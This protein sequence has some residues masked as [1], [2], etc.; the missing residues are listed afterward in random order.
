[1]LTVL[2]KH[3]PDWAEGMAAALQKTVH[4]GRHKMS[5][6]PRW[7]RSGARLRG[8]EAVDP[9][10]RRRTDKGTNV[11]E[12]A[13]LGSAAWAVVPT[14]SV[15]EDY[16]MK[17][18]RRTVEEVNASI[19]EQMSRLREELSDLRR[20]IGENASDDTKS[21][22]RSLQQR[23]DR[24]ADDAASWTREGV[25][26]TRDTIAQNPLAAVGLALVLGVIL[27]GVIARR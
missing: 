10:R 9:L 25:Q 5:S 18:T 26:Q 16:A 3:N 6:A 22:L 2:M 21:A 1:L 11:A 7:S 27:G 17:R 20:S 13:F 12:A 14:A 4:G 15:R 8:A 23:I 24:L 19:E